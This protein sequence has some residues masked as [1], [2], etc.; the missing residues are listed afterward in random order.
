MDALKKSKGVREEE[1][2]KQKILY[3]C[4]LCGTEY[5]DERA[6][7]RCERGHIMP[8]KIHESKF[9]SINVDQKGYPSRIT[10][11]MENGERVEYKR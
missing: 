1:E 8:K 4:E 2:M 7:E 11:L 10:I 9:Q 3:V 5:K 6:A